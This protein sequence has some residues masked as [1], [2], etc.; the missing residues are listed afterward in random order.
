MISWNDTTTSPPRCRYTL[1]HLAL[2]LV[3]SVLLAFARRTQHDSDLVDRALAH[4]TVERLNEGRAAQGEFI[5]KRREIGHDD[6]R[7]PPDARR[8]RVAGMR[9][10]DDLRPCLEHPGLPRPPR[11]D[12]R[13]QRIPQQVLK[14]K[15]RIPRRC[16]RRARGGPVEEPPRARGAQYG[17]AVPGARRFHAAA[18]PGGRRPDAPVRHRGARRATPHALL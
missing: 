5:G 6:Q 18:A 11:A 7:I 4:T 12:E 16:G 3:Y 9:F 13:S 1:L 17:S 14:P 8:P 2:P 10:A 15:H